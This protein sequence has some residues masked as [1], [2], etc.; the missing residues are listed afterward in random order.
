MDFTNKLVL[1]P[2]AGVC[3]QPFRL[4]AKEQGCDILYTEMISA[5]GLYYDNKITV[6]PVSNTHLP[7]P[8]IALV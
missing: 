8:K 1:A 5:K 4:L 3:D 7:L 6:P 2:M